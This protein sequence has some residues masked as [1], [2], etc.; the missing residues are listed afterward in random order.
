MDIRTR[1][2]N[3][4]VTPDTEWPVI[5]AETTPT[6]DL[7]TGYVLPLAAIGAIAGFIGRSLIGYSL[8]YVGTYREPIVSGLVGA[9]VVLVMAIVGVF[10]LAFIIN[11]LAPT[12]N[13]EQSQSQALKLAAYSYTPAWVAAALQILPP[14]ALLAVLGALYGFYLLY[15]GL[16]VL[17]KSPPDK[18]VAYT[19]VVVVAAIILWIVLASVAGLFMMGSASASS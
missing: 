13:G 11:A 19:A 12:F 8:P 16:P 6:K 5:A 2:R 15:R 18:A 7:I 10:I 9:L 1:A 14:L 17:M 3:I 4:L